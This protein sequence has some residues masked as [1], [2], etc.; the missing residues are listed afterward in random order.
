[1]VSVPSLG[2]SSVCSVPHLIFS[3]NDHNQR[4]QSEMS[5]PPTTLRD[6]AYHGG[7]ASQLTHPRPPS[8]S[9]SSLAIDT[10]RRYDHDARWGP[11]ARCDAPRRGDGHATV[12]VGCFRRR[13]P[14]TMRTRRPRDACDRS[15]QRRGEQT[16]RRSSF[17][18]LGKR[19]IGCGHGGRAG[20]SA[21]PS[22]S[23]C[24][25]STR[26]AQSSDNG[27]MPTTDDAEEV[28]LNP[29]FEQEE[30]TPVVRTPYHASGARASWS[31]RDVVLRSDDALR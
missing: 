9:T 13:T 19:P 31:S 22:T 25:R 20:R 1:M 16:T 28:R 5:E 10:P 15:S 21:L 11:R 24:A 2:V 4:P 17:L 23:P 3:L 18:R 14:R 12:C 27:L 7:A 26:V 29:L 6:G 30:A 8:A